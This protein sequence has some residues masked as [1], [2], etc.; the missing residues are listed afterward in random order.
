MDR[1]TADIKNGNTANVYLFYGEDIYKRRVYKDALRKALS[2]NAMNYSYFEGDSIDWQ[3]AADTAQAFPFF[4]GKRLIIIENSG[5]FKAKG[6]EKGA[7][8]ALALIENVPP[9]TCLAFFEDEVLKTKKIFKAVRKKGEAVECSHDNEQTVA[10]WLKK[11]F[12][13]AGKKVGSDV[14]YFMIERVG[15]DYERLKKEYDKVVAYADGRDEITRQDI[16][17]VTGTD[18]DSKI[19]ELTDALGQ[20]DVSLVLEKYYGL[21]ANE[22]HPL[23][24]LAG[25]RNQFKTMLAAGELLSKGFSDT[26][27]AKALGKPEFVVRKNKKLL[28]NF[29]LKEIEDI[30]DNISVTDKN[31]KDGDIDER[32]G[33]EILLIETAAHRPG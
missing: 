2:S 17:A 10:A 12:A 16:E 31:I 5:K 1:I 28:R 23:I 33:V 13:G 27:T 30:I 22:V 20:K 11:G 24:I 6:S 18:V 14:I 8:E 29:S 19:F 7:D 26:E 21:A 9:T 15:V 3:K 32:T 4:A 25:M